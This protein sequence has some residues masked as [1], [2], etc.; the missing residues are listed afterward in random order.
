MTP[1]VGQKCI[2]TACGVEGP[3]EVVDVKGDRLNVRV[4][5]RHRLRPGEDTY[6]SGLERAFDASGVMLRYPNVTVRF[7]PDATPGAPYT[8][9]TTETGT[10]RYVLGDQACVEFNGRLEIVSL[11][12]G[13]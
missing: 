4:D 13:E 9:K 3:G 12:G 6:G 10:I 8:R 5:F 1:Y 2:V 7:L 11:G